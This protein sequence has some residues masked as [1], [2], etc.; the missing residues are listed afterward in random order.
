[1]VAPNEIASLSGEEVQNMLFKAIPLKY[2]YRPTIFLPNSRLIDNP[3]AALYRQN[4]Y[5]EGYRQYCVDFEE[6]SRYCWD[7]TYKFRWYSQAVFDECDKAFE[8]EA[9]H[10]KSPEEQNEFLARKKHLEKVKTEDRK[11]LQTLCGLL[12]IVDERIINWLIKHGYRCSDATLFD[13]NFV[14]R[15]YYELP[16]DYVETTLKMRKDNYDEGLSILKEL[17]DKNDNRTACFIFSV[18]VADKK[19]REYIKNKLLF[20]VFRRVQWTESVLYKIRYLPEEARTTQIEEQIE[21]IRQLPILNE[22]KDFIISMINKCVEAIRSGRFIEEDEEERDLIRIPNRRPQG[23]A[24]LHLI[25]RDYRARLQQ[26]FSY[27]PYPRI[28]R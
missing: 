28:R 23:P 19:S 24:P 11:N 20:K 15:E 16:L 7:N 6:K 13:F 18:M 25:M 10:E 1:M 9:S 21:R 14:R 26:Y 5:I 2:E 12:N 3:G 8:V 17:F 4:P 22:R 27:Y